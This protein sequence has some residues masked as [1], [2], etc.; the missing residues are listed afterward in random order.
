MNREQVLAWARKS[1]ATPYTNRHYPERPTHT[2]N[3]E[4]LETFAALVAA[5]ERNSWP[6]EMEAMERQVNILTD[7]LA[8]AKAEE[9]EQCAKVCDDIDTEYEGED[10]LATWCAAAIRARGETK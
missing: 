1:G 7:A 8:Q 4:Q 5:A 9:R 3:V 10:V 6:A 2:F